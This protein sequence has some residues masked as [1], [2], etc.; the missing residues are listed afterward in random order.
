MMYAADLDGGQRLTVAL[1]GSQTTVSLALS[2]PGQQQQ[3]ATSYSTGTWSVP[4]TLWRTAHGIVLRIETAERQWFIAVQMQGLA[5][6]ATPPLLNAAQSIPFTS[7]PASATPMQPMQPMKP[8]TPMQPMQPMKPMQ[9]QMG[10]MQM[11][12]QPMQM[13]MGDMQLRQPAQ[14][15][16][17][18][19][20]GLIESTDR[21]CRACGT[22]LAAS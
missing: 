1:A 9:M 4:P 20:Q 18:A 14:P 22:Q 2:S 10:D 11:Q 8:M 15:T 13:Q 19:C 3:Q 21:F 16:C 6:L 7:I 12:M 17:R 5:V